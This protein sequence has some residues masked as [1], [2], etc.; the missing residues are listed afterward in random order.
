[1]TIKWD[2]KKQGC[3]KDVSLPDWAMLN[4]CF[5]LTKVSAGDI[6][7]VAYQNGKCLFFEKKFPGGLLEQTQIRVINS[8]VS[9]GNSVIAIW[10]EKPDGSDIKYMRVWGVKDYDP[11]QRFQAGLADFR[12]AVSVWWRYQ[13][14]GKCA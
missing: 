13:Y 12:A 8:L 7:G 11:E 3:Y 10:C 5:G 6:D 2:C 1:M 9:Q 4:G 14:I